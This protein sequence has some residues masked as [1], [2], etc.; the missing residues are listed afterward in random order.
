MTRGRVVLI[1]V[2]GVPGGA[3]LLD[4]ICKSPVPLTGLMKSSGAYVQ[5]PI[6]AVSDG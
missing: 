4:D 5:K 6:L 3:A 2:Y 1:A